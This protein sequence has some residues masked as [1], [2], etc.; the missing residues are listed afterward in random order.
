[1]LSFEIQLASPIDDVNSGHPLGLTS[2][3]YPVG[4]PLSTEFSSWGATGPVGS[5]SS[6][7]G[8]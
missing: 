7:I 6:A 2:H 1:M 3:L 5:N 4:G 8:H